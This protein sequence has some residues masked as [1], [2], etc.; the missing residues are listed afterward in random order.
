MKETNNQQTKQTITQ[1]R[2]DSN[3]PTINQT[4]NKNTQTPNQP[5]RPIKQSTK[6]KN[7]QSKN[8]SD[9]TQPLNKASNQ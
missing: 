6:T 9:K 8:Q 5:N 3:K 2:H 4:T 1:P 7:N